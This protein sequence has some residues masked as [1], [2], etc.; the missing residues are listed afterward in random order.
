[1]KYLLLGDFCI[2]TSAFYL[3]LVFIG[4]SPILYLAFLLLSTDNTRTIYALF[5]DNKRTID[6]VS[7]RVRYEK[8]EILMNVKIHKNF[9]PFLQ[10][11]ICL[12]LRYLWF[13]DKQAVE[14]KM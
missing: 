12:P 4:T 2:M 11:V 8:H 13:M 14:L 10:F 1:M 7:R 9:P 6:M 5:T 3:P